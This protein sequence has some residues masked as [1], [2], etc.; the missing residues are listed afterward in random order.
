MG[1]TIAVV[2]N[3]NVGKTSVFNA[4]TGLS[5]TTGNYPGVTV[6][7]K[8]GK[9]ALDGHDAELIDLPGA[10]SLAARS[11]DEVILA[12]VLLEQQVGEGSIDGILA[13]VDAANIERN[14]YFISQLLELRKPIVLALNMMDIAD[15]RGIRIDEVAL[16]Q[17]LGVPVVPV[18]A[19][20]G[21]GLERLKSV[22]SE[23]VSAEVAAPVPC[24]EFPETQEDAVDSLLIRLEQHTATLDRSV[25]RIEAF[26]VLI[27]A[28]GYTEKRILKSLGK[29]FE[30]TLTEHR[31]MALN[32]G[33]TLATVEAQVRYAWVK[34]VM[35]AAVD[36]PDG[37]QISRS[38]KIDNVLT[39]KITGTLFFFG[40][41]LLIFQAIYAWAVPLMD[42]VDQAMGALGGVLETTIPDGVLQSLLVNGVV[43]GVGSVLIFL[44]QILMLSLFIA[45][46][47]DCGYMSRAAFLMDKLLSWCGLSGQSFIPMMSSFACAIPGIMATRTICNHRDRFTTILVAPL[48]S[49]S[50]RL[51]VYLIMIAAFVPADKTVFG[52]VG[53]QGL[54]LFLMYCL[55]AFIAVPIAWLLKKTLFKGKKPPFLLEMPS[56]KIPQVSAVL[57][58]VYRE[59]REFLERAGTLIFSVTVVVWA[60]AYFPH[61]DA[62]SQQFDQ[63]RTELIAATPEGPERE[64]ALNALNHLESGAFLDHS[65]LGLT[66]KVIEPIFRPLG[67]DWRIAT[68]VI[69]SFPARE[70][71]VATLGTLFNLGAEEDETSQGLLDTLRAA[72][73]PDDPAADPPT[74]RLLFNLPVALSIMVFFALCMQCAAT[75]ATMKRETGSWRW[76][77]LTFSYMTTLA[78]VAA[79][80]TYQGTSLLG[81]GS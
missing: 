40:L 65:Y 5:Q 22:I 35:K 45:I 13:V 3:P 6:D 50:A 34:N 70:I 78:Y 64:T 15:R 61:A 38:E 23:L 63:Q 56:Y 60:L 76:P 18:C 41:M 10:Y 4:L 12:D 44:P 48:M 29:E 9:L 27:D 25:P 8:H 33:K 81:W 75:L 66:G 30:Q 67:W 21:N 26:R 42:K 62:I 2:G 68:A 80:I 19:H 51:P 37:R 72:T 73:W 24:C 7:R 52:F 16:S 46:L 47:E 14:L 20:N 32:N 54:T 39:H 59:G 11:P 69:A 49:C 43:A 74:G 58:K 17:Q 79:F 57:N 53:L 1:A 31:E 71:I 36:R 77:A 28:G 55:G